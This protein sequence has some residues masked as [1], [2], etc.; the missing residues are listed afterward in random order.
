M[1]YD[2]SR[3]L[4]G[5]ENTTRRLRRRENGVEMASYFHIWMSPGHFHVVLD[6]ASCFLNL[7]IVRRAGRAMLRKAELCVE[8]N[9]GH[10]EGHGP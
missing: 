2:S 4:D 10:V 3:T 7:S 9:G 5:L 8:E 1:N 6:V